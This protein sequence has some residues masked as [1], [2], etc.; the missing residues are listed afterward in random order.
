AQT[1]EG[2]G[3]P[4][5][6]Q[7]LCRVT[8]L[9]RHPLQRGAHLLNKRKTFA[10]IDTF[11]FTH[12]YMYSSYAALV[13]PRRASPAHTGAETAPP[14]S[15]GTSRRI[16]RKILATASIFELHDRANSKN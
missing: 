10:A 7:P 15:D 16:E 11:F 12:H 1:L 6:T 8:K 9:G 4:C 14:L 2:Y 13:V 3:L 5:S